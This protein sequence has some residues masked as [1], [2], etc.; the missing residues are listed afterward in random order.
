MNVQIDID[1]MADVV[2][3]FDR[4]ASCA[5]SVTQLE[6][7]G[8][9]ARKAI[10]RVAKQA[11]YRLQERQLAA[12][13]V[14]KAWWSTR[15]FWPPRHPP[16]LPAKL[17]AAESIMLERIDEILASRRKPGGVRGA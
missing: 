5:P 12:T 4:K 6:R 14:Q 8:K 15:W 2:A 3:A 13:G 7:L 1:E 16:K 17:A 9:S 11:R 10:R